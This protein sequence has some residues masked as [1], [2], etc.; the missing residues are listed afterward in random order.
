MLHCLS[1]ETTF[2]IEKTHLFVNNKKSDANINKRADE[3]EKVERN[4][5]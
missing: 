1:L 3:F 5:L 2:A 4:G